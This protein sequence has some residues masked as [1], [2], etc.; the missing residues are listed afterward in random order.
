MAV[1][2]TLDDMC[3]KFQH[4]FTQNFANNRNVTRKKRLF[5]INNNFLFNLFFNKSIQINLQSLNS[6]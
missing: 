4:K 3:H 5:S 2:I 1:C 6:N